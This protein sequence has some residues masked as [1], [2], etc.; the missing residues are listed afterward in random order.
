MIRSVS[1]EN[2]TQIISNPVDTDTTFARITSLHYYKNEL[3]YVV[4]IEDNKMRKTIQISY[5]KLNFSG[6]CIQHE[7]R[8]NSTIRSML[9]KD[10]IPF[11]GFLVLIN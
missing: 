8:H 5:I 11:T 6:Y 1:V 4:N 10:K 2:V 7:L 3:H 9:R